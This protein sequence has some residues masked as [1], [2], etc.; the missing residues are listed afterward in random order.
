MILG[1]K[2]KYEPVPE[3]ST[4]TDLVWFESNKNGEPA[5][6]STGLPHDLHPD[7]IPALT[8]PQAC[9]GHDAEFASNFIN[10]AQRPRLAEPGAG[11][12]STRPFKRIGA[13]V[14]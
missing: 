2:S 1:R 8:E 6:T 14:G 13:R 4:H 10:L 7:H 3:P 9:A 12:F 5:E 11:A